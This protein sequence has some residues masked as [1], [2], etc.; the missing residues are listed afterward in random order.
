[1]HEDAVAP[2]DAARGKRG[3]QRRN[4]VI[5]LAPGPGSIAPDKAD[6]VA[7]PAGIL[8][9]EM[10]Q[11]HHAAR[12]SAHAARWRGGGGG[13]AHLTLPPPTHPPPTTPHPPHRGPPPAW[14]APA[15]RRPH[16][17]AR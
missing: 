12:P 9:G 1:M 11:V 6:T 5:D 8:G 2:G 14:N 13:C 10:R 15:A 16:V 17:P 3:G 4:E 7:M